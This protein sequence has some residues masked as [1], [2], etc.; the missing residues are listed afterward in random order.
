LLSIGVGFIQ[1]MRFTIRTMMI[2]TAVVAALLAAAVV[3]GFAALLML[4]A[5]VLCWI[6]VGFGLWGQLRNVPR[7]ARQGFVF[8]A[9]LINGISHLASIAVPMI[10]LTLSL[11]TV[12][13]CLILTSV[14]VG[15]GAAWLTATARGRSILRGSSALRLAVVIVFSGAPVAI[16]FTQ[17]PLH[18]AFRGSRPALEQLAGRV[19]L[20]AAVTKPCWAGAFRVVGSTLDPA[21]GNIGL[22]TAQDL[23]G[24]RGFE[25][26][27]PRGGPGKNGALY[28]L[29]PEIQLS[30]KWRYGEED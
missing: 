15:F 5:F 12:F 13:I 14:V 9:V 29:A 7:Q 28:N 27:G 6:A 10:G 17:W 2:A 8:T 11:L 26:F 30:E 1:A 20:G 16:P 19:A 18:L 22:I 4:A 23:S 25:R 21:T 3:P 24:R